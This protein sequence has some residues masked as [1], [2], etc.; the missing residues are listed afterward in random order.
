MALKGEGKNVSKD[1]RLNLRQE[2]YRAT[3]TKK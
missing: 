2:D 3:V 1:E